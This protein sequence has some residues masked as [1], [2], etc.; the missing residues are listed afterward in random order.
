MN[1]CVG[2]S[3][4][5]AASGRALPMR[6]AGSGPPAVELERLDTLIERAILRLRA[7]YQLSLDELRG[8][9]ISDAQVDALLA[10]PT[11][12][13]AREGEPSAKPALRALDR[14]IA[15]L[16]R[17]VLDDPL[18]APASDGAAVVDAWGYLCTRLRLSRAEA[19]VLIVSLAPELDPRYGPLLAYLNDDAAKRWATPELVARLVGDDA[20]QQRELRAAA[21]SGGR[22][23][24]LGLVEW[25][26]GTR[27]ASTSSQRGLRV[28][29]PLAGWLCGVPYGDERLA[30]TTAWCWPGETP[31][32][33]PTSA[34]EPRLDWLARALRD[35]LPVPLVSVEAGDAA[36]ALAVA[37][38]I[39]RR[40]D[41]PALQIDL[42][43]L[44]S[45]P[46]AADVLHAARLA[47]ALFGVGVIL[48]QASV[49]DAHDRASGFEAGAALSELCARVD[50]V[51]LV[52]TDR[53]AGARALADGTRRE[54]LPLGVGDPTLAERIA[55]WRVALAAQA[56]PGAGVD[57]AVLAERFTIGPARTAQA[58]LRACRDAALGRDGTA[59]GNPPLDTRR[60]LDA[61][62]AVCAGASSELTRHV[63]SAFEWRD[64]VLPPPVQERLDD[65]VRAVELRGRVLEEWGFGRSLGVQRGLKVMFA[66]ASGTGKSMAAALVA[67]TL[68]LD[69]HRVELAAVVSKY[70]GETE[71]NLDRAFDA[72]RSGNAI[73]F[74]DEA[75]ALFG[76]RS[77]VK[78]AHDRYANVETA[79]LLQK[80]E[81]HDGVVILATNL[82]NNIDTAFSRRMHFVVEF[83]L[84]DVPR[85][86]R[87][88]RGMFPADAP[89]GADVDFGFLA[90]QFTFAGGDI[91]NIVLDASYAA[92][93]RDEP[94]T[95]AHLLRAVA[96]QYAKRGKVPGAAEFREYHGLLGT[97]SRPA[98]GARDG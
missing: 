56:I 84:P 87:L 33:V 86:E 51:L 70:I 72:A 40:A 8:L 7:R 52:G 53:G 83:P 47:N 68:A 94:I 63:Q 6:D 75:D 69:L 18:G 97:P 17:A 73:L 9:Y 37:R 24:D 46:S 48:T 35:G 43:A 74:I 61:A 39:W 5:N 88:W 28:A 64:L 49:L 41:R 12:H 90:R 36:E 3:N 10:P 16:T 2:P 50:G 59:D 21:A 54:L 13:V 25:Q 93:H 22:L 4:T 91:R 71:K 30:G 42:Q 45:A 81:D 29:P 23:F 67:K 98:V 1:A 65:I 31:P 66:G 78:D 77:E 34:I 76:K 19:D 26:P 85:R 82:A 92:A 57:V 11:E 44:R 89:L 96:R 15:A 60:L 80:M 79:Y 95:M 38:E 58:V 62:R 20:A 27:D 32:L 55:A 14:R